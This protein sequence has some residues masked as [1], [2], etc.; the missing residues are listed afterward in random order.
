MEVVIEVRIRGNRTDNS[1]NNV[2]W[3]LIT[4]HTLKLV[5]SR[6]DSTEIKL[7]IFG[8]P[9]LILEAEK[10]RKIHIVSLI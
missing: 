4:S 7:T 8:M 9:R 6:N 3:G 5:G 2:K 10:N 1:F